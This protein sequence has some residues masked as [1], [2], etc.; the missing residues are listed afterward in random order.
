MQLFWFKQVAWSSFWEAGPWTMKRQHITMRSSM[1]ILWGWSFCDRTLETVA[2]PE[3]PGRSIHSAIPGNRHPC[4]HM[5]VMSEIYI[6]HLK[7]NHKYYHLQMAC[8]WSKFLT[9]WFYNL[10][11]TLYQYNYCIFHTTRH[12]FIFPAN[13]LCFNG[14]FAI[15]TLKFVDGLWWTIFW[16]CGLSGQIQ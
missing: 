9:T 12:V 3:W 11:H 1:S 4:L 8:K 16:T 2:D 6:I 10:S 5:W 15:S 7:N 13:I 14:T